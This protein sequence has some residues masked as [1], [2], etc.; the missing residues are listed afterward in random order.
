MPAPGACPPPRRRAPA[1]S[2]SWARIKKIFCYH[3]LSQTFTDLNKPSPTCLR[4]SVH[5]MCLSSCQMKIKCVA[6]WVHIFSRPVLIHSLVC[7]I[8]FEGDYFFL[9]WFAFSQGHFLCLPWFAYFF[10]SNIFFILAQIFE[11]AGDRCSRRG[12][13]RAGSLPRRAGSLLEAWASACG[14]AAR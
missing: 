12:P 6:N 1:V 9:P 8:Y 10:K 4:M 11:T 5:N 13:R 2:K 14:I 3:R 7:E